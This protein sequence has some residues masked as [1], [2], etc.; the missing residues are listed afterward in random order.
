MRAVIIATGVAPGMSSITK[1]RPSSALKILDKPIIEHIIEFLILNDLNTFDL[2]LSHHPEK[3][4]K[5]LGNGER[6]GANIQYHLISNPIFP[7]STLPLLMGAWEEENILFAKGTVL[8]QFDFKSC[9]AQFKSSGKTSL[10]M[11]PHQEWSGWGFFKKKAFCD[12]SRT[13]TE[14]NF[15]ETM[16]KRG[17]WPMK[18]LPFLSVNS[19]KELKK[20]N[21]SLLNPKTPT[22]L[23][24][25]SARMVEPGIWISRATTLHPK[26]RITPPVFIGEHCQIR[27]EANIGPYV[28][29]ENNCI[30]DSQSFVKN[31][32]VCQKSYI[33]E[34][35]EVN[36]SIVDRDLLINLAHDTQVRIS[37]HFILGEMKLPSLKETILRSLGRYL[38]CLMIVLLAPLLLFLIFCYPIKKKPVVKVPSLPDPNHWKIFS[39]YTFDMPKNSDSFWASLP[40]LFNILK[41]DMNITGLP[42]RTVHEVMQL[43]EDWQHIHLN[44]KLGLI[45]LADVEL[46]PEATP[47]DFF[48]AE[49]YYQAHTSVKYDI[50]LALRWLKKKLSK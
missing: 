8:P 34:G 14:E 46:P 11:Y 4:E 23:F 18:A 39:L 29:I 1:H 47:E 27:E 7:L 17:Y 48:T 6:W 10:L 30:I 35:L 42:P 25:S 28:V 9:Y 2:V 22:H 20:N 13:T 32:L 16:E 38:A 3:I 49:A 33:G 19:Y 43:S 50:L 12:L 40:K 41:G 44:G 31:T 15:I 45:T 24:P 21:L 26:A 37:D 36:E 5:I